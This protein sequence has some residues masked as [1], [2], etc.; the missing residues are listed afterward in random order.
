METCPGEGVLKGEKFSNT[1]KPPHQWVYGEFCNL[2][3]QHN[4][5]EKK[6]EPTDY[7]PSHEQERSSPDAHIRQQWG[8]NREAW[9]ACIGWG[10]SLNAL[11]TI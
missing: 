1:R 4:Q 3:G 7:S 6:K 9:A 10:P 8:L 11:R 5:K 2:R